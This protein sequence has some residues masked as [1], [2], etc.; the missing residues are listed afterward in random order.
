MSRRHISS[1]LDL[2]LRR[3]WP[4][5]LIALMI[6]RNK[7]PTILAHPALGNGEQQRPS[8]MTSP[9]PNI[10]FVLADDLGYADLSCYGRRDFTI[11][12]IDSIAAE[13]VRFTQAYANS[14]VC[15]AS[16]VALSTGRY[17]YRLAVGLEEP[18]SSR[19]P[20]NIGLP[21]DDPTSPSILKKA[22]YQ[23]ALIG[24]RHLGRLPEFGPLQSGYDYFYGFRSGSLPIRFG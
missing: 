5:L 8:N 23:F 22:G 15:T 3:L 21:T 10:L 2:P 11:A 1:A 24:K 12:N 9:K 4:S 18:L 20:R 16:R 14:A 7:D 13:G 19:I 6:P 17:Q